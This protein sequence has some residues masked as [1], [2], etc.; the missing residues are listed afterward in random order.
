MQCKN[1]GSRDFQKSTYNYYICA[2][3]GN[4]YY[5]DKYGKKKSKPISD[6]YFILIIGTGVMIVTILILLFVTASSKKENAKN[7]KQSPA[8]TEVKK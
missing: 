7:L 5:E 2:S 3:C 4:L 8:V 1:C 6:I